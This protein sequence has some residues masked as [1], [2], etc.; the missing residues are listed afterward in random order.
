MLVRIDCTK[1]R[2]QAIRVDRALE[3]ARPKAPVCVQK[4]QFGGIRCV[5]CEKTRMIGPSEHRNPSGSLL[6]FGGTV[7]LRDSSIVSER[8]PVG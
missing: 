3:S 8:I 2:S 7:K 1:A 4:V 6:E 5:K